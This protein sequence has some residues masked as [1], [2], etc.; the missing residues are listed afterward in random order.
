MQ[1]NTFMASQAIRFIENDEVNY[2]KR[3]PVPF[4]RKFEDKYGF[5]QVPRTLAE[6]DPKTGVSFFRGFYKDKVIDK[7]QIYENGLLCEA[8]EDNVLCDEFLDD[9][10]DWLPRFAGAPLV[11]ITSRAYLS[12][13]EVVFSGRLEEMVSGLTGIGALFAKALRGYGQVGVEEYKISGLRMHYDSVMTP[14]PRSPEFTL[15][16]RA[17]H[18]HSSNVYFTS[19]PLQT[20]DHLEIIERLEK[21]LT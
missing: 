13:M 4:I 6:L 3:S 10:F 12:Q 5:A 17:G 18:P 14:M 1:L 8:Q 19:A 2:G 15:E 11:G 16:R 21:I 7:F 9:V 20:K